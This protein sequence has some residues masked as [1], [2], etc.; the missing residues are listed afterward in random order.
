MKTSYLS[1]W[2]I[3]VGLGGLLGC[4]YLPESVT[5]RPDPNARKLEAVGPTG[6][7][8]SQTPPKMEVVQPEVTGTKPSPFSNENS[9][10]DADQRTTAP[11][12]IEENSRPLKQASFNQVQESGSVSNSI[13]P[14]TS[15]AADGRIIIRSANLKFV[16]DLE[17]AAQSDGLIMEMDADEGDLLAKG[18][19]MIQI[20]DRIANAEL[21]KTQK[22]TEAAL[23][24]AKDDSEIQ[25]STAASK[26]AK[27]DYEIAEQLHKKGAET[28]SELRKKWL[29]QKRADLAIT[30]AESKHKQDVAAADVSSANQGA[31][32]VQVKLRKHLAQFD[33]VVAEKRKEKFDW[34]RAGDVIMRLVSMEQLRVVG[35]VHVD[36]LRSAPH[37][38]E[39]APAI[40]DISIYPGKVERVQ[41]K[42][43]F[44]SPVMESTGSYKI[45]LQIPNVKVDDQWLF[46]EGMPATIE[47]MPR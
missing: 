47:I 33:G 11:A 12:R 15:M 40:V 30:V 45:W 10:P 38:L 39:K 21:L 6:V 13:A 44:V 43:G 25:Y 31:A 27:Q 36:Q 26:V 16:T 23:E 42:V 29:E 2:I 3:V 1:R 18:S 35:Y 20:D 4:D 9:F 28:D 22:E 41:A 14:S 19:L 5:G 8:V 34:V 7:P 32:E 37:L 24:K 46:R 17:V